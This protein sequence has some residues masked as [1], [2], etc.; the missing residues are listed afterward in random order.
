MKT[1]VEYRKHAEECRTL[2]KRARSPEE[3]EMILQMAATW[4]DLAHARERK[5]TAERPVPT[6]N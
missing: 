1:V 5:I 2:A 6:R 3:R 4:E